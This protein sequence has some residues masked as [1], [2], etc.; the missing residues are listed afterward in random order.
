MTQTAPPI[1]AS[2]QLV[3]RYERIIEISQQLASTLD[4]LSLLRRIVAAA[5]ELTDSETASILLLDPATGELRFEMA[6]NIDS[7]H[8]DTLV[9]PMNSSIAGWVVMHGE[10]RVIQDVS[11]EPSFFPNVDEQIN[12][13]TRNMLAVP[14][15][16]HNKVIG[17]LEAL[18][19]R[20]GE[21][22]NGEDVKIL[23]TLAV[24][25][26]IAIENSRLFQ[27]SDFMAEMVH[28]LRTPLMA[29][30]T[31]TSLLLRPD[32]PRDKV[33]DL[34]VTMQGETERLIR[35]TSDF[36]DL[37]RL[38]S[39]RTK[40]EAT[41]VDLLRLINECIDIVAQQ[42][43]A[44]GVTISTP[45]EVL[46]VNADRGKIKQ[47][48]L[49]LLTNAIK[50]NRENGQIAINIY[51]SLRHDEP[52]VEVAVA[53][54]GYGISKDNQKSLF[55]KFFRVAST[56]N[57]AVGTGLGLAIAKRIVESHGGIIWLESEEG[58]GSTFFLTLPMLVDES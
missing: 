10:P 54:T 47:V 33:G 11:K 13:R 40:L 21:P 28:E 52:F 27:Q 35:L 6:P 31:S 22:Y 48:L 7:A 12:F 38:E 37:A 32:L 45:D 19:K 1:N 29:L 49:N 23:T 50:Y 24:Q 3:A 15:R 8:V 30:K 41:N 44:R 17:A 20:D 39:G 18:N 46:R 43:A 36:L 58:K 9:V 2:K 53:D 4:H 57:Q 34:I 14:M 26:A 51:R 25:A 56:A 42:A 16:T 5:M 55:Q